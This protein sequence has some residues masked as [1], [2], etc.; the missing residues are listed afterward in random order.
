MKI[1]LI[2]NCA[3]SVKLSSD[4]AYIKGNFV[5]E[6][7]LSELWPGN[8]APEQ[9]IIVIFITSVAIF[10]LYVFALEYFSFCCKRDSAEKFGE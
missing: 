2:I 5:I 7:K 4:A 3:F 8:S 6:Q 1:C 9:P 10:D